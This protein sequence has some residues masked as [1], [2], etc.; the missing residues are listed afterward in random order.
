MKKTDVCTALKVSVHGLFIF[1]SSEVKKD[2]RCKIKF[3]FWYQAA[4]K[5]SFS[6]IFY[7]IVLLCGREQYLYKY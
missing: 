5:V 3:S 6:F 7:V 1:H 2:V 4:N